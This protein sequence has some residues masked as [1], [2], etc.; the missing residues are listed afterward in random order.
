[1]FVPRACPGSSI[2]DLEGD[3]NWPKLGPNRVEG[4][5]QRSGPNHVIR[6]H[7]DFEFQS[8]LDA[9]KAGQDLSA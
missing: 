9:R 6:R 5:G 4:I 8:E 1:M 3:W 2:L 7:S